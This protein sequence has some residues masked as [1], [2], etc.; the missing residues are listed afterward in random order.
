MEQFVIPRG[1][2]EDFFPIEP[3]EDIVYIEQAKE[4]AS[5]GGI[6]LAATAQDVPAGRVV[7][8]GPGRCY[9]APM[10][11]SGHRNTG[12]F[13]P[14]QIK[15]GDFVI[16]GKYQSGGEPLEFDG[17]TFIV[18]REGDLGGRSHDGTPVSLR[19]K[20]TE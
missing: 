4:T 19:L 12:V 13:V 6:I 2:R 8:V 20:R 14:T 1:T 3:F 5:K 7:A 9:Q 10:D 16:F 11:A 18:A 17:R 15:V